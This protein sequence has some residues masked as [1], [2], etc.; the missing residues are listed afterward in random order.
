[1]SRQTNTAPAPIAKGSDKVPSTFSSYPAR[2][3]C[4]NDGAVAFS[5]TP[6]WQRRRWITPHLCLAQGGDWGA[7]ITTTVAL[8][9]PNRIAMMHTTVPW[10]SK[11]PGFADADLT[12]TEKRWLAELAEFRTKGGGY[13][14]VMSTRPQTFGYG[15]VDSPV[16]QLAWILE[17]YLG[18][19]DTDD[20]GRPLIPRHRILD[21]AALY[22]FSASAASSARL[23]WE[24]LGKRGHDRTAHA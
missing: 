16:G 3:C 7:M 5:K 14:A 11:P 22:W 18:H 9:H 15:L 19:G 20:E 23:Y 8:R 10:A 2:A 6:L 12:E 1:M 4:Q 13:A 24:S 17:A 21:N